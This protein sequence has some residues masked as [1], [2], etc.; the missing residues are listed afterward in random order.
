MFEF[1][2]FISYK[3]MCPFCATKFLNFAL[4]SADCILK[5]LHNY[6]CVLPNLVS[7]LRVIPTIYIAHPIAIF[8]SFVRLRNPPAF[9]YLY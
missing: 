8:L 4:S 5:Q 1:L 3:L 9:S 6:A 7:S 2:L